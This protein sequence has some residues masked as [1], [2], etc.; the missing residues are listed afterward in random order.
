MSI[1]DPFCLRTRVREVQG[2]PNEGVLFLDIGPLLADAS[3]FSA[4]IEALGQVSGLAAE[5]ASFDVVL[6]VES[7]GFIL[8]A[9]L[10]ARFGKGFVPVR[11]AGK[12]PPPVEAEQYALEYGRATLEI[13]PAGANAA[14]KGARA[15]LVDDVL[16]TG[17]TL[18]AALALCRRAGYEAC[19]LAAL[20]NISILNKMRFA[21]QEVASVIRY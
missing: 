19:G 15:L 11:K 10:A 5:P 14:P 9:A 16:A 13:Q 17:G 20:I 4:A 2:F 6:G 1:V 8:A 21:G 18:S 3:A 12:L 7:R